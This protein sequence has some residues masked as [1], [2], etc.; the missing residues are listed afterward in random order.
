MA[1]GDVTADML[2][3]FMQYLATQQ[4]TAI[5]IFNFQLFVP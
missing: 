1:C 3:W 2:R 4:V 5:D